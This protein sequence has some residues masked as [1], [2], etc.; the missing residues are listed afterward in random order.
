[1]RDQTEYQEGLDGR[2]R[3]VGTDEA[4]ILSEAE[5][6]LSDDSHYL[7]MAEAINPYDDST[8]SNQIVQQLAKLC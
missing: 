3:L 5:R 4:R 2:V 8:S 1:M 7:Q 6:L